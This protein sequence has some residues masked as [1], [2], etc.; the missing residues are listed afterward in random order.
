[1][2][3]VMVDS[4]PIDPCMPLGEVPS[5]KWR[6]LVRKRKY[7]LDHNLQRDCR[8]LV[9]FVNEAQA[10]FDALGYESADALIR[11]GYGLEPEEIHLAVKWL[12]LNPPANPIEL[13]VAI[14]E[15][16]KLGTHG[17]DRPGSGRPKKGE[18]KEPQERN[19]ACNARLKYGTVPHTL[20]RL[21]RDKPELA[22]KVR[23][24]ELSAN[25][26]AIEAGFR[27]KPTPLE[28][29][30]RAWRKANPDERAA[31]RNYIDTPVMD[32]RG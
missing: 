1:M 6:E 27:H 26:A 17:G 31:F 7:F 21:D 8:C 16:A 19:Q 3:A 25:A 2:A 9:E 32:R 14:E 29:L 30:Q 12:E 10:M 5:D 4:G 18:V 28:T 15:G 24:G 13:R 11:D 23:A 22:E 20:A